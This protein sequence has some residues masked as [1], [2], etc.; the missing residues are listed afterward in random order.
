MQVFT[1]KEKLE[2]ALSENIGEGDFKSVRHTY[3][4][5]GR[6]QRY[7]GIFGAVKKTG[8]LS[9]FAVS[10]VEVFIP[11]GPYQIL[12]RVSR[13][14]DIWVYDAQYKGMAEEIAKKL[15]IEKI[16]LEYELI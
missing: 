8:M 1:L 16:I 5:E 15:E 9:F 13:E 4:Y 14:P 7:P 3:F 11:T 6:K 2:T 10:K 12:G